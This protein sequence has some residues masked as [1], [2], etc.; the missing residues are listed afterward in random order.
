[1]HI[2]TDAEDLEVA[3]A[4]LVAAIL[5]LIGSFCVI[6]LHL[7]LPELRTSF[8]ARL[9]VYL[10]IS[11]I[12][13]T[14]PLASGLVWTIHFGKLDN[15]NY[16]FCVATGLALQIFISSY[17]L[18]I[19]SIGIY[20]YYK[21][22]Q[23]KE[24]DNYEWIFH[25]ICWGIPIAVAMIPFGLRT[26]YGIA[27]TWCWIAD[28]D[29]RLASYVSAWIVFCIIA[30]LYILIILHIR[31]S[32]QELRRLTVKDL[33]NKKGKDDKRIFKKLAAFPIIFMIQWIPA[34]INR[35]QNAISP[36]NEIAILFIVHVIFVL[37]TGI[38][39]AVAY[40]IFNR[41]LI[42]RRLF[43]RKGGEVAKPLLRKKEE[44]NDYSFDDLTEA[45]K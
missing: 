29:V 6:F 22:T 31:K 4:G 10:S 34:T 43:G 5:S 3:Y 30:I 7:W 8:R 13:W 27:G 37:S 35:I 38:P 21:I 45:Q 25:T 14:I 9:V 1:M 18:W 2:L 36:M 28:P 12:S 24:L 15:V 19:A 11:D 40:G 33:R 26:G 39:N 17:Q 20:M 44:N 16:F 42:K 41:K 32:G 23:N